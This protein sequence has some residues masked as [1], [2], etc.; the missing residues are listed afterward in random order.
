[1]GSEQDTIL[2]VNDD[3]E[4]RM[5]LREQVFATSDYYV[6]EAKDGADALMMVREQRP[7]LVVLDLELSGLTGQDLLVGLK[8][9]GYQG[10]L[11]V[12]AN[13]YHERP[14]IEA[15]RLGATDFVVRPVRDT[16]M[17]AAAE[18]GL[19]GVRLRRQRDTLTAQ[20]KRANR[21]LEARVNELTTLYEIGQ[22]VTAMHELEGL[23]NHVLEGALTVTGGDHAMLMLRDERSGQMILRAGKNLPLPRLDRLG[24]A[25]DDRL[26]ELVMTSRET[27]VLAGDSLQRF[28]LGRDL[29]A[30]AYASLTVQTSAVG[31]LAVGNHQRQSPFDDNDGRMLTA[32]ANYAAIGIVNA[33]LNRLLDERARAME[34]AYQDLRT[35]D[36]QRIEQLQ[37][38][39]ERLHQPVQAIEAGLSRVMQPDDHRLPPEVAQQLAKIHQDVRQ[40]SDVLTGLAHRKGPNDNP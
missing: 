14:V 32:L 12:I 35:R 40:L 6:L 18:R 30:V 33:R 20:L 9:Q 22:S 24:E 31:V 27:L 36:A 25:I 4:E 19:S 17:M 13:S 29:Y 23:F 39:L 2:I 34:R 10:P 37:R 21:D 26:A 16:E 7:H 15:F 1:M 38:L 5:L 8:A 11:I 3:P 28:A